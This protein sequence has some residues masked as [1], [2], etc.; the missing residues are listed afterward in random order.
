VSLVLRVY[1]NATGGVHRYED[2]NTV[3]VVDGLY[4]TWLGGGHWSAAGTA[5]WSVRQTHATA[6]QSGKVWL[7]AGRV[8]MGT[9]Y[10]DVWSLDSLVPARGEADGDNGN[11]IGSRFWTFREGKP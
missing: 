3:T 7:T 9:I 8:S 11:T 4:S 6:V 10:R 5:L 2:S 1:T